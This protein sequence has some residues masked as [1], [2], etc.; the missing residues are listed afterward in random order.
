[1]PILTLSASLARKAR[2]GAGTNLVRIADS[3][4]SDFVPAENATR[5]RPVGLLLQ[6][7]VRHI[8]GG[9]SPGLSPGESNGNGA[10]TNQG[11]VNLRHLFPT[12]CWVLGLQ[13]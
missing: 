9:S 4:H 12:T 8:S 3:A 5:R 13:R 11:K 10:R 6:H 7:R 2:N 1:R